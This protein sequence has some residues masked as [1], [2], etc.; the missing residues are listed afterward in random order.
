[1]K[2]IQSSVC[3]S[4]CRVFA[5]ILWKNV[6]SS[7]NWTTSGAPS[8]LFY[9]GKLENKPAE[10]A[11]CMNGFFISKIE[12]FRNNLEVTEA[13]PLA[14]L[15]QMMSNRRCTFKL[16]PVH[17]DLVLKL[18]SNLNNSS[19]FGL[20]FIDTKV[21]KLVKAE[22]TPAITHIINLSI[23]Q[24]KFPPQFKRAK[25]VPLLKSGNLLNP[26]NYRPVAILPVWSKIIKM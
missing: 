15:S 25:V 10:L 3:L 26:K 24:S 7:L 21:I 13:D 2:C 12:N 8:Q 4:A 5:I 11:K 17:P 20:D 18:I 14:N 6:K 23:N 19:S 22:I 9:N 1:M 16:K